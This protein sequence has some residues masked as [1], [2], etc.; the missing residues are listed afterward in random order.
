MP[1]GHV[2]FTVAP[3]GQYAA[4]VFVL[5]HSSTVAAVSQKLP[6][7]HIFCDVLPAGQ[8][9][10][11]VVHATCVL[12]E[13]QYD[14]ASHCASLVDLAGQK[15]PKEHSPIDVALGQKNPAGHEPSDVDPSGQYAPTDS[16]ASVIDGVG[17]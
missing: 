16:H 2:P 12:G 15:L 6:A 11:A 14:P 10:P 17:Q 9:A 1:P 7:G 8:Y 4:V 5:W 13:A 3:A